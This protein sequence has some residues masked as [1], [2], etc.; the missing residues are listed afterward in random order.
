MGLISAFSL[1]PRAHIALVGGGG[2]T[3]LMRA[4]A[5]ELSAGGSRV[6]TT[7]TTKV[8]H[9]EAQGSP[10]LVM[11]DSKPEDCLQQVR[12]SVQRHSWIFVGT[13]SPDPNKIGGIDP[14]VATALF[15]DPV[16]DYVIV[17]ADGAAGRPV[18]VPAAHEPVIPDSVTITVAL[19]GLEAVGK[20]LEPGIAFRLEQIQEI[21]GLQRGEPLSVAVLAK[22]F[23]RETGLFRGTPTGSR[24]VVFLNKLDALRKRDL[25]HRLAASILAASD[26]GIERVVFGSLNQNTYWTLEGKL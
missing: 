5:E 9:R 8:A 18:K 24:N 25:A 11:C 23:G 16:I 15:Q 20:P 13:R 7:T 4:L 22:L 12:E 21:T 10:F 1:G 19:L 14:E 6:A 26:A 3:T 2:K 17:E